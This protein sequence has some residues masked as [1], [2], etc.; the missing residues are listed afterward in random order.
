[1]KNGVPKIIDFGFAKIVNG[2]YE[3]MTDHLGTPLYMAPQMLEQQRYTSKC[4]IW[5]LGITLHE[6]AFKTDPYKARDI[7]DLRIKIKMTQPAIFMMGSND[8]VNSI[9]KKCLKVDENQRISWE[10]LFALADQLK[11][12]KTRSLTND[13][14]LQYTIGQNMLTAQVPMIQIGYY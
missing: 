12:S 10:Q 3:M 1:L 2:P 8:P 7:E 5:S 4:D 13:N 14:L 6:L 11:F 9:I